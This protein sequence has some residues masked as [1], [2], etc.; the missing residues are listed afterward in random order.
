MNKSVEQLKALEDKSSN[1]LLYVLAIVVILLVVAYVYQQK[2]CKTQSQ[3]KIMDI[4]A[5]AQVKDLV[6]LADSLKTGAATLDL[7]VDEGDVSA[8][9]PATLEMQLATIEQ[10]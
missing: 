2:Q 6:E 10:V 5:N 7:A 9:L 4:P 3:I 8:G 1:T